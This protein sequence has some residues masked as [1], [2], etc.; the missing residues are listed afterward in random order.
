[1]GFFFSNFVDNYLL[2]DSFKVLFVEK[3]VYH[4]VRID[5]DEGWTDARENF[6]F[7][8]STD[9]IAKYL[10]LIEHIHVAHVSVIFFL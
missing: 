9:D 4:A 6:V 2:S 5:D 3:L 10:G 1:M 8:V 7:L